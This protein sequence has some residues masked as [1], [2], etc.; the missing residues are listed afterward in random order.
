MPAGRP[1]A[2]G[3]HHRSDVTPV[4]ACQA[5]RPRRGTFA[6]VRVT[7]RQGTAARSPTPA[8]G[9]GRRPVPGDAP[10][11]AAPRTPAHSRVRQPLRPAPRSGLRGLRRIRRN[12]C[13]ACGASTTM[14]RTNP[15]P[16]KRV[17][18]PW[19]ATAIGPTNSARRYPPAPHL[20]AGAALT[21]VL[22]A[23]GPAAP[24]PT[25]QAPGALRFSR[26]APGLLKDLSRTCPEAA[27]PAAGQSP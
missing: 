7:G 6:P 19:R 4:S 5:G 18:G 1:A 13:A 12:G 8:G 26:T 11:P 2:M 25:R 22:N 9:G 27:S 17:G 24:P 20:S 16:H 15:V 23:K 21:P 3:L 10:G 14:Q